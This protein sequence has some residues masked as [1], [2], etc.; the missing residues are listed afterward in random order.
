VSMPCA[1]GS[2][3]SPGYSTTAFFEKSIEAALTGLHSKRSG[4]PP[5]GPSGDGLREGAS[6]KATGLG[7]AEW[8]EHPWQPRTACIGGGFAMAQAHRGGQVDLARYVDLPEG[9]TSFLLISAG[10]SRSARRRRTRRPPALA[11]GLPVL[12]LRPPAG[13]ASSEFLRAERGRHVLDPRGVCAGDDQAFRRVA[14][15]RRVYRVGAACPGR[16][17]LPRV[18]DGAHAAYRKEPNPPCCVTT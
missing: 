10:P 4:A 17:P 3:D 12:P 6:S 9:R 18:P 11:S 14:G 16:N 5:R 2:P 13:R 15:V 1:H 8:S 7:P